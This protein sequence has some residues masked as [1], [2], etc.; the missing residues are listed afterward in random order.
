MKK[1]M[2]AL[3]L[4]AT[5]LFSCKKKNITPTKPV[6][7]NKY[8][9]IIFKFDSINGFIDYSGSIMNLLYFKQY[10]P[11]NEYRL[12][13]VIDTIKCDRDIIGMSGDTIKIGFFNIDIQY[14]KSQTFNCGIQIYLD[15]VLAYHNNQSYTIDSGEALSTNIIFIIP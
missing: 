15:S 13:N 1:L 6:D 8:T 5:T 2:I 4:I 12:Y 7:R 14:R 9:N 3:L 10:I 11:I